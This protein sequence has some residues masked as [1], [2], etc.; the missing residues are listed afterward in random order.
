MASWLVEKAYLSAK[1]LLS[2]PRKFFEKVKEPL[3][4]SQGEKKDISITDCL[5]SA[6]AVFK[7]KF[8]SLL[9]FD[10][11][12]EGEPIKQN[13]KNLFGIEKVPS[14]TYICDL[15]PKNIVSLFLS[16][17]LDLSWKSLL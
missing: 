9:Q 12:R 8:P 14:D 3:K 10:E 4:G 2:K 1:G 17:L 7:L 13:L 16:F 6:L 11:A 15:S 5:M